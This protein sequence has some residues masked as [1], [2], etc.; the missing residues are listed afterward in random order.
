MVLAGEREN[1]SVDSIRDNVVVL[2]VKLRSDAYKH[3]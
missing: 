2:E 1:Y 3:L